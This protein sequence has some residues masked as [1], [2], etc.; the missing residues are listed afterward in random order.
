MRKRD[1]GFTL[2]E[3]LIVIAIIGILAAIAIPNLLNAVQRGKQKRTMADIKALAAAIESYHVDNSL[4]PAAACSPGNF[5]ASGPTVD[6]VSFTN[7][8]PTYITQPP[9][10]D[11][12]GQ[13]F[14]YN[15]DAGA[16][17]YNVRSLGRNGTTNALACGTTTDFNEDILFSDGVFLQWPEG[18]QY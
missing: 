2:I 12:W 3:L 15:T 6:D 9:V 8:T 18:T 16:A 17:N 4:Y 13:F 14:L 10:R 11:G 7:L 1:A 5:T